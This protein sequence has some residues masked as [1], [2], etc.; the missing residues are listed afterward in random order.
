[1]RTDGTGR[2]GKSKVLQEVLADL[3]REGL[4]VLKG[5]HFLPCD[6]VRAINRSA[7]LVFWSIPERFLEKKAEVEVVV[8]PN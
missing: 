7:M 2:V 1:M 5:P 8:V 4:K 6:L 3:K